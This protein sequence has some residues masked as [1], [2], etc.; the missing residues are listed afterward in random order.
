VI[1]AHLCYSTAG[2][3]KQFMSIASPVKEMS[4][5]STSIIDSTQCINCAILC[6]EVM[7]LTITVKKFLM[8]FTDKLNRCTWSGYKITGLML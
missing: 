3:Q 6:I 5:K 1:H 4:R 7:M 8:L 2:I